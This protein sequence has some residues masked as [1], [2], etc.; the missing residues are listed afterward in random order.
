MMILN[1]TPKNSVSCAAPVFFK[2]YGQDRNGMGRNIN[3]QYTWNPP[4]D[5]F[6][7]EDDYVLRMEV[8]GLDKKNLNIEV[9]DGLLTINGERKS[10][11]ENDSNSAENTNSWDKSFKR[12]FR[13][14]KNVEGEKITASLKDGV[15][16]IKVPKPEVAKPR[17]ISIH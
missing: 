6:D 2:R 5:I 3:A 10:N 15:L 7:K 16:E 14:P 4:T 17:S 13:L 1:W 8:P 12:S 11:D 9:K